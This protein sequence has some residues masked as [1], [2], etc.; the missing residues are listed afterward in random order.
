MNGIVWKVMHTRK[1]EMITGMI[2]A[3]GTLPVNPKEQM[4]EPKVCATATAMIKVKPNQPKISM[5]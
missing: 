5:M 4:I 2:I 3:I 1:H